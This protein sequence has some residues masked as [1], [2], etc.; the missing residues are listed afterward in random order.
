MILE[1]LKIFSQN[2][3]KNNFIIKTILESHSNFDIIFIQEPSWFFMHSIPYHNNNEG[4]SLREIVNY[5]NWLTFVRDP[6]S[7]NDHPRVAIFINTRLSPLCFSLWKDIINHRDILLSFF[8]NNSVI[9]WIINVYSDSS[10]SAI[11]YLKDTEVN[12][13]NLL[14]ITGDFNICDSLW[15]PSYNFHSSIS[16]DF[17]MITNSFDLNLSVPINQVLTRYSDNANDSNLVIDLMFL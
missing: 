16:D 7:M 15:D 14:I 9:F 17:F 11:K 3:H 1:N 13:N 12:L 4:S 5:P 6:V 10:H 2:I 8:F